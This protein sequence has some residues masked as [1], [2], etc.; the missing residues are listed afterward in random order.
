MAT[1]KNRALDVL[2]RERTA[3]NFAPALERRL[4]R[5]VT[6]EPAM[7]ELFDENAIKDDRLRMMFS[8]CDP[9]LAEKAQV[10]IVLHLLCGFSIGEIAGAFVSTKAAVE[11]RIERARH[12]LTRL[13]TLF[14]IA[15][16][17]DFADRLP[18]VQRALYL[19]FNEGY[20][21][22][23]AESPVRKELCREAMRLGSLLCAHSLG[24]TPASQALLALMYLNAA[25]LPARLDAAGDLAAP[26]DTDRS[27]W[28][29]RFITEGR[30]LLELASTG[31]TLS[32]YHI[33]AAIAAVHSD[34]QRIEETDWA[35]IISYYDTLLALAPSAI[36]ELN[37]AVAVGQLMGPQRGL[38]EIDAIADGK[39]LRNYPFYFAARGEFELQTGE[40]THARRHFEVAAGLARSPIER[41][42]FQQRITA[43]ATGD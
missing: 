26:F 37:R 22:A 15:D 17:A 6:V 5:E 24:A 8:C 13:T 2:R 10:A 42:F 25:R 30:R 12:A 33:E 28:N 32:T 39:R 27:R 19:L 9:G 4:A 40:L 35:Q 14:D 31:R 3:R 38:S 36:V 16:A 29:S 1:A 41:R 20:H 43:C 21:G 18:S 11:K 23:S 34:A 7:D